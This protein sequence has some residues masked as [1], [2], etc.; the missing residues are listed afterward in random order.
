M[1]DFT[2]VTGEI[3]VPTLTWVS[4]IAACLH[5][6]FTPVF[7]DINPKTSAMSDEK[8]IQK[9]N[10]NTKAVFLTHAQGF[11]GLTDALVTVLRE[12]GVPL[13]EDVCES[14]GAEFNNQRLGS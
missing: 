7:A 9:L 5:N 6:G 3:I 12:R 4:D 8:L 10:S 11:N 1:S 13:I 2:T 14:H